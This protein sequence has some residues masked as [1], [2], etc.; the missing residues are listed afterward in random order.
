MRTEYSAII[1]AYNE[2]ERISGVIR[3][4]KKHLMAENIIVVDDGSTDDTGRVAGSEGAHLISNGKNLGKGASLRKGFDLAASMDGIEGVFT[5]D[6]DGQHDPEEIPVFISK[7]EESGA[8]IVI[9]DR[10]ADTESMPLIRKMT[11]LVTSG[12]ISRRSGLRIRDSQS[13]YRLIRCRLLREIELVTSRFETESEILIK[14]SR[15]GALIESVPIRTIYGREI[16]KIRPLRDT[17]RFLKLVM[18][19]L[20][21]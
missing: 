3:G 16:S 1:P 6:A 2:E 5:V 19:S 8:D 10:M 12:V 14:A 18:R 21:W 9:G 13:G 17:Y 4:I 11:N 7:F 20:F 15:R